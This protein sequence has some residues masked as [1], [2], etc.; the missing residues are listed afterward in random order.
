MENQQNN[1]NENNKLSG[2]EL[3]ELGR[4]EKA[5]QQNPIIN[6]WKPKRLIKIIVWLLIAGGGIGT[7]VWYIANAPKI[8]ESDI[9][10]SRGIHWHPNI[11]IYIKGQKQEIPNNTGTHSIMHTHDTTGALHIHPAN[12]LVTKDDIKLGSFFALWGKEFNSN[13]IFDFC[14]GSEGTV[15]MLVNGA[16]NKD[17]ENYVMRDKD[18][19]EIRYE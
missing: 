12:K 16:E 14:N 5:K 2:K 1:D 13:C 17:F 18:K 8:P 15:K 11:S 4:H 19:I 6:N 3:Y 7:L 10:S 9:I